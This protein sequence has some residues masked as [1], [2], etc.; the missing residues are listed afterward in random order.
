MAV[1]SAA[2]AA[3]WKRNNSDECKTRNR[4]CEA[5]CGCAPQEKGIASRG[6]F[7]ASLPDSRERLPSEIDR[8]YQ[9]AKRCDDGDVA[10]NWC[11]EEQQ[12][13]KRYRCKVSEEVIREMLHTRTLSGDRQRCPADHLIIRG[14]GQNFPLSAGTGVGRRAR[15]L[16]SEKLIG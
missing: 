15:D 6:S 2:S 8:A 13:R 1:F 5:E 12:T 7:A 10:A 9:A 11:E 16:Q 3:A 14:V 4:Y